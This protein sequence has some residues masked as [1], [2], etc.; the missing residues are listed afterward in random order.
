MSQEPKNVTTVN[1][2]D[3]TIQPYLAGGLKE[4]QRLY[5]QAPEYFQGATYISPSQ[6]TEAALLAQRNR[7]IQGSVLNPAAQGQQLSTIGGG[8]LG[9]N[10][11]FEGA[12]RGASQAAGRE[13]NQAVNQA[14]SNAS[15]AGRYGSG[16]MNMALGS[17]NAALA[18]SLSNT[19]GNLAYQNYDAERARQ[20]AAA[21]RAPSMAMADYADINQ[22]MQVGQTEESYQQAA[23]QDAINRYNYYQNLPQ[24][25]LQQYMSYVYGAPKGSVSTE[26]VFR[27]VGG[28]IL[29]GAGAGYK[30][31]GMPGAVIG[32]LLGL[33]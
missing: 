2:I 29:G 7:A 3:P 10:P 27:N 16:A 22:L 23:L 6:S 24:N 31:G 30:I 12:F 9:G 15:R 19:A 13:Y 20:E 32:G 1:Q 11:F 4:A 21:A 18:N 28:S 8:Y 25:Q 26:P 5:S 33:L 17:A 14:L